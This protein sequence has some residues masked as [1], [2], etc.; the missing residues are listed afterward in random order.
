MFDLPE[1]PYEQ[2]ALEPVISADTMQFHHGKHHAKYV[3]TLN[4]LLKEMGL[5]ERDLESLILAAK[6]ADDPAMTKLFNNAAQTW[7]HTFF[8]H[9]MS[10]NRAAP[11]PA[12]AEAI[13]RTFGG[14][15]KLAD[16][17]VKQG[18][19]HFG[20]G[21]V[22]LGAKDGS[23]T[24]FTTHDADDTVACGNVTPLLVCDLWEHAYY[25]DYQ[26]DRAAFLKAWFEALPNWSLADRQ[27]AASK[28]EG[29]AWKH[30]LPH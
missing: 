14:P 30:P 21:W 3:E 4:S 2:D 5:A 12:L 23:L 27:F 24:V 28:G 9:A 6:D 10:D 1:L 29:Q 7:N 25:L 20:S 11:G 13:Q 16:E 8:W 18:G 22:W 26:N 17:F 19:A 15:D